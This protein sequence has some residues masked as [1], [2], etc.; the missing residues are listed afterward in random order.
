MSVIRRVSFNYLKRLRVSPERLRWFTEFSEHE[1]D[2]G[3]VEKGE[4]LA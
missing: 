1:A 2:G 4:R 3:E